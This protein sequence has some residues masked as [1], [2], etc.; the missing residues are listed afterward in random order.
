[1]LDTTPAAFVNLVGTISVD[2]S[3]KFTAA[4]VPEAR[5]TFQVS[6]LPATAYVS[7]IRYGGTSV[8][9]NGFVHDQSG[10]SVQIVVDPNGAILQGTVVGADGK[11]AANATVVLV[12]IQAR[13]QNALLYKNGATN[14]SGTFTL[15]GISPGPYTIFA[16]ESVPP[17]AWQNAEFLSKFESRGQQIT[18]SATS[19][20]NVQLNVI[21]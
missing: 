15:R 13:R 4:N 19:V 9:D 21:P 8:M 7:D 17:T 10:N 20:A 18:L 6:G 16:W 1:S 5:Y 11:P 14:E 3:G 12:P 2:A